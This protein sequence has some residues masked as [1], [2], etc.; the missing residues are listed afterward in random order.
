MYI[1]KHTNMDKFITHLPT[2]TYIHT[3]IQTN[4]RT[5]ILRY[6]HTSIRVSPYIH[7]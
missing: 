3:F 2:Y 1:Y 4:I 7:I 5:H 6:L